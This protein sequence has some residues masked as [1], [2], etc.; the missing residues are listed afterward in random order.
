MSTGIVWDP[1]KARLNQLKHGVHFREVEPVFY[2][3]HA[4]LLEDTESIGEARWVV[5]GLDTK[6][7]LV[8]VVYCIRT[9]E[10]RVVSARKATAAEKRSYEKRV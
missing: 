4:I 9:E 1:N 6:L 5:I 3:P 8:T 7:R 2:D 10:I